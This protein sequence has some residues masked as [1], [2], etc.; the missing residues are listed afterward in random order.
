MGGDALSRFLS[1]MLLAGCAT[2]TSGSSALTVSEVWARH[3][4]LDGKVIRVRGFVSG[5][6]ILGCALQESLGEDTKWLGI[7]TSGKFDKAVAPL[8]GR[9]IVV[10][11]RL[12]ASCLHVYADPRFEQNREDIIICTDRA[13]MIDEPR[14]IGPVK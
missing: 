9:Q 12:D 13:S 5:C 6:R 11:G 7:G 2:P 8:V 14:L 4:E 3:H 10:K 1:L